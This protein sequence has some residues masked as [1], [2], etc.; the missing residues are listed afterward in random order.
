[1]SLNS[2]VFSDEAIARSGNA[3]SPGYG[4][5]NTHVSMA[6]STTDSFMA[7]FVCL[8]DN[9]RVVFLDTL[10]HFIASAKAYIY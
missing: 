9:M 8:E 1:M 6:L 2:D 7:T 3:K 4:E 10:Q 5:P